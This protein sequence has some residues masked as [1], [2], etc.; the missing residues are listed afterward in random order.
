MEKR[1]I[2]K[3][4]VI[5]DAWSSLRSYTAARIA[6]GRTGISVPLNET[7]QFKMAHANAR[8]AVYSS[9]HK[10]ALIESIQ[11]FQLPAF[12]LHSK[13][14]DRSVYLQRPDLGRRLNDDSVL[15][16]QNFNSGN[17]HVCIVIADG[18]SA[19][20][21]NNHAAHVLINL[22]PLL[23]KAG[24][25]IAPVCITEQARVAISDEIGFLLKA[26][27]SVMLIGERP[28]LS[29]P[30]SLGV[31]LTYDPQVGLTD[32]SR[33]CISN[34]RPEGLDYKNAADK[35]FYLINEALCL[36]ISGVQLKDNGG[37]LHG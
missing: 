18:L 21:I 8:D 7:L 17:S 1:E 25:Q 37:L 10:D 26:K 13:A 35:I 20:A 4:N 22:I 27:L 9:L 23:Q 2:I 31:Y 30:D 16:L 15:Q 34:I 24:L 32:E 28:G 36:K 29:S 12:L 33:N 11:S 19:P 14:M 5:A 6:L 3:P